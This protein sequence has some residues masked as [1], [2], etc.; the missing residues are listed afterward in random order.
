MGNA[1]MSGEMGR[2][3]D[4]GE[5]TFVEPEVHLGNGATPKDVRINGLSKFLLFS[6][7]LFSSVLFSMRSSQ[8]V[9]SCKFL[10]LQSP[11]CIR[12]DDHHD[13]SKRHRSAG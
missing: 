12:L 7:L 4:T 8:F 3:N 1:R 6:S 11:L 9:N 5:H 13:R 2:W 10:S